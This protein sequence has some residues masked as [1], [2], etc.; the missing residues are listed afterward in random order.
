M[1]VIGEPKKIYLV[2]H[3]QI[4][5]TGMTVFYLLLQ[6]MLLYLIVLE[7]V[8]LLVQ[9][10]QVVTITLLWLIAGVMVGMEDLLMFL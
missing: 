7:H 8:M 10:L 3:V 2:C 1:V 4:Q 5:I 9:H 6:Q